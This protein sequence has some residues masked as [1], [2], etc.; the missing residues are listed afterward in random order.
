MKS[1][2]KSEHDYEAGFAEF[3]DGLPLSPFEKP[4]RMKYAKGNT[5]GRSRPNRS[6]PTGATAAAARAT[7]NF[8][9]GVDGRSRPNRHGPVS[10]IRAML[11]AG[12]RYAQQM[13]REQGL[14][15][16]SRPNGS[17]PTGRSHDEAISDGIEQYAQSFEP[18]RDE[19][20]GRLSSPIV[21]NN[22]ET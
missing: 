9:G 7:A 1:E 20:S 18:E 11:D 12:E 14:D 15:G 21:E 22:S 3:G 16:R 6:G 2:A 8:I 13:E 10:K 17:R 5:N 4:I 19:D